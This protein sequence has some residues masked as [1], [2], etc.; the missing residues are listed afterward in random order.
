MS[1]VV[2][3]NGFIKPFSSKSAARAFAR[4]IRGGGCKPVVREARPTDF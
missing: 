4:S 1:F 3:Y 2:Q